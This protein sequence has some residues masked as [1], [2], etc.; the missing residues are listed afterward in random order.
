MPNVSFGS[1]D[2]NDSDNNASPGLGDSTARFLFGDEEAGSARKAPK[3]S[4]VEVN[5]YLQMNATEDKFPILVRRDAGVVCP[6]ILLPL[7]GTCDTKIVFSSRPRLLLSTL[8]YRSQTHNRL[9]QPGIGP[10]RRACQP[11]LFR[12][13]SWIVR[14]T[15]ARLNTRRQASPL[16]AHP[17]FAECASSAE[18]PTS[19]IRDTA[20]AVL[21]RRQEFLCRN[22]RLCFFSLLAIQIAAVKSRL[23]L[24]GS[25]WKRPL[26]QM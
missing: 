4:E 23:P 11:I 18:K 13:E 2:S 5:S 24:L 12:G 17:R 19:R 6:Y 22:C 3:K 1:R 10:L 9:A 26:Q 16:K 14:K 20:P 15:A 8:L 7:F 21:A 25:R